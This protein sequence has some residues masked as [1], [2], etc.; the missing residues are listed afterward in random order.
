VTRL[1]SSPKTDHRRR[2][3]HRVP[4]PPYPPRILTERLAELDIRLT[5]KTRQI[6]A[7]SLERHIVTAFIR[8]GNRVLLCHRSA[9]RSRSPDVWD[10]PAGHVEPGELP[11]VSLVREL[12]QELGIDIAP[13]MG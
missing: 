13:P 4:D 2:P 8:D 7:E 11:G 9:Q 3:Q 5:P 6:L 1:V 12:R 10:L